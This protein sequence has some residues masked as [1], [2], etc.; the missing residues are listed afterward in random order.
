MIMYLNKS[1]HLYYYFKINISDV[2]T[3]QGAVALNTI[4]NLILDITNS[5]KLWSVVDNVVVMLLAVRWASI[6][7]LCYGAVVLR[8]KMSNNITLHI[9]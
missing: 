2:S 6:V 9:N 4:V 1:L 8:C 5:H 3:F 7:M